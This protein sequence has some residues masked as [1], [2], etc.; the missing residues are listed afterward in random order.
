MK[1]KL[2]F[3]LAELLGVI[4]I[5]SILALLSFP[6]II[7][8]IKQSRD[9]VSD[10]TMKIIVSATDIYLSS[11]QNEFPITPTTYCVTLQQLVDDDKLSDPIIDATSGNHYA[12]TKMVKV[13]IDNSN[14]FTYTLVDTCPW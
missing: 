6:P 2:G 4:V 9:K 14:D 5:I 11:H 3:T 8:Q 13:V 7:N 12:L 10:A 1:N